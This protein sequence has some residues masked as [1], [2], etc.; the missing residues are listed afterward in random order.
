MRPDVSWELQRHGVLHA[1]WALKRGSQNRFLLVLRVS[2]YT[3]MNGSPSW[4]TKR[5]IIRR[6]HPVAQFSVVLLDWL[7]HVGA[8]QQ[9][10]PTTSCNLLSGRGVRDGG[11]GH[12]KLLGE[13][14]IL[15]HTEPLQPHKFAASNNETWMEFGGGWR[16]QPD[17]VCRAAHSLML[18]DARSPRANIGYSHLSVYCVHCACAGDALLHV[19]ATAAQS[20]FFK[21]ISDWILADLL[22]AHV[23][24][25]FIYI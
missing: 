18:F 13:W 25:F 2:N 7:L 19:C 24:F 21:Y 11:A 5:Y 3:A 17:G 15:V 20:C 4:I 12:K 14:I 6:R 22:T 1:L 23:C 9:R 16:G 8:Q 10:A